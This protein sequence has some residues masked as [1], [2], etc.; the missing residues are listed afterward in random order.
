MSLTLILYSVIVRNKTVRLLRSIQ[1]MRTGKSTGK[2][3]EIFLTTHYVR[4][5]KIA[6]ISKLQFFPKWTEIDLSHKMNA[7]SVWIQND[8]I[9]AFKINQLITNTK[10]KCW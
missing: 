6:R 4:H 1:S 3:F 8:P 5:V 10:L 7:V 9:I 2:L